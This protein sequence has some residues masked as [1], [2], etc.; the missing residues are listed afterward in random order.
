MTVATRITILRILLIPVFVLFAIYYSQSV[1]QG[2]PEKWMKMAAITVF[3]IA[4]VSDFLDGWVA[5][6]FK[7]RSRLGVVLDPIADKA[8]LFSAIITLCL[9]DWNYHLPIWFAVLVIAR[10]AVILIGFAV[11]K[12]LCGHMEVH[13]SLLGK[14]ATAMQMVAISWVMLEI[15][16]PQ[17]VVYL[18]GLVTL[19]SGMGYI[20]D[21]TR[22]MREHSQPLDH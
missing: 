2:S 6:R 18:A 17:Y 19:L 20:I 7:Q 13:P 21:G 3:V 4:S 8:L 14:A 1:S 16:Y 10:D 22:Q 12:H 9:T 5:R 15:Q 11:V